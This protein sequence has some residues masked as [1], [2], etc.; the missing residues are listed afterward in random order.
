MLAMLVL[1]GICEQLPLLLSKLYGLLWCGSLARIGPPCA[2]PDDTSDR[3]SFRVKGGLAIELCFRVCLAIH[4]L[5]NASLAVRKF[6]L[7]HMNH[8]CAM[9]AFMLVGDRVLI[10][11][12]SPPGQPWRPKLHFRFF[13][14]CVV[15]VYFKELPLEVSVPLK[16]LVE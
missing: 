8:T 10:M 13:F 9:A 11:P 12:Y 7:P 6:H 3:F 16:L 14:C 2:P 5:I 4:L 15:F 1:G